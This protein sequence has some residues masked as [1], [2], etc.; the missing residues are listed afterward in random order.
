MIGLAL[1]VARLDDPKELLNERLVGSRGCAVHRSS[2]A[3]RR[4]TPPGAS[5]RS[6]RLRVLKARDQG[7]RRTRRLRALAGRAPTELQTLRASQGASRV[8]WPDGLLVRRVG[9]VLRRT[10]ARSR[11]ESSHGRDG[12]AA[13]AT[14]YTIGQ[15]H[16]ADLGRRHGAHSRPSRGARAGHAMFVPVPHELG[17]LGRARP[18]DVDAAA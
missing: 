18:C 10:P 17:N 9:G 6:L 16:G 14:S 15:P 13:N 12:R 2:F 5:R 8:A 3:A 1:L 7:L 4:L 11:A